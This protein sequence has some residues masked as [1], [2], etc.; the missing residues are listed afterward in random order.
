MSIGF[1]DLQVDTLH[2]GSGLA[3]QVG[4]LSDPRDAQM[5]FNQTLFPEDMQFDQ[6]T[7]GRILDTNFDTT[8]LSHFTF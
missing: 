7:P 6:F 2:N 8:W 1:E 3:P 4:P 5:I